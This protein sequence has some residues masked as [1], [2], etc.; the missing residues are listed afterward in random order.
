MIPLW[1]DTLAGIA[2]GHVESLECFPLV[3]DDRAISHDL[4]TYVKEQVLL[5][6]CFF[7]VSIKL[8]A[9]GVGMLSVLTTGRTVMAASLRRRQL[10]LSRVRCI[11][12]FQLLDV[13]V[14]NVALLKFFDHR[15]LANR[16]PHSGI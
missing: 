14:R 13:F 15:S 4:G 11:P 9:F 12:F 3:A 6:P 1:Q 10:F 16:F 2:L 5:Q 8:V 7:R